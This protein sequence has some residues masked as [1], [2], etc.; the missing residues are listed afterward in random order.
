MD[1][2]TK[3]RW[4]EALPEKAKAKDKVRPVLYTPADV[5]GDYEK[6]LG[7]PGEYPFTRG[8]Y[9]GMYAEQHWRM[10]QQAGF[11]NSEDTNERFK[12]FIREGAQSA[13]VTFDMPTVR[14]V[15]SDDPL[16]RGEVGQ[17]GQP[18]D[19]VDDMRRLIDG[20]PLEKVHIA[21]LAS[22][23]GA[24]V[25]FSMFVEAAV[26]AGYKPEQ[27]RGTIQNEFLSFYEGL[28]RSTA[29]KPA[30]SVRIVAD[31]IQYCQEH[32]PAF[33][34]VNVTAEI[35]REMGC[36]MVQEL[37][38][39]MANGISYVEAA[40][41][42]GA[43]VDKFG[44]Q[45]AFYMGV[46]NNFFEEI[47]K[48]R[49]ARRMWAKIMRERFGAKNPK[50]WRFRVHAQENASTCT[51]QQPLN[52]IVRGTIQ[53]LA[54]V[55]GGVQSLDVNPYDEALAIPTEESNR[56]A[57]RTQQVIAHESGVCDVIDPLGGS[58]Y[59]EALTNRAEEEAWKIIRQFEEWGKGSVLQG[60]LHGIDSGYFEDVITAEAYKHEMAVERKE[61]IVVGVNEYV[62]PNENL[63]LKLTYVPLDVENRQVERLKAWKK[64][65]DGKA[66]QKSLEIVRKA[67]SNEKENLL[68]PI[69]EAVRTG[70]TL[71]ETCKV[72]RESLGLWEKQW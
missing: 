9:P 3:N 64:K 28:P 58:Y 43:D 53:A 51:A 1:T 21:M 20:I 61:K 13:S 23:Q 8:I 36:N 18:I 5:K 35:A 22:H 29:Y 49:A 31:T 59:V 55:L 25:I 11:G 6:D 41:A 33:I 52:N 72:L 2:Q 37:A 70:A 63:D 65:R 38:F 54:A 46:H 40:L 34:P 57:L 12:F 26:Q 4:R 32:V 45:V 68:P 62:V 16:A 30:A 19:T 17:V 56:V 15:D 66:V 71:G 67:A 42:K 50:S 10:I 69:R 44:G 39:C 48:Y 47:A 14:G 7:L 27:L 24:P 60:V